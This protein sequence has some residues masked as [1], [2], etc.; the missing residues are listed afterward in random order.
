M[1]KLLL[2]LLCGFA[3]SGQVF[4]QSAI[5][6]GEVSPGVYENIK[7]DGTGHLQTTSATNASTWTVTTPTVTNSSTQILAANTARNFFS[8][9]NNST[10]G[11]IYLGIGATATTAMFAIA[12]G[13]TLMLSS[14]IPS[15]AINAIGSIAS[16][17]NVVVIEG[18]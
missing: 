13:Q 14:K 10:S 18:Q 11:T 6:R 2:G 15:T 4:A 8:V 1:K 16:N 9:Q 3:L 5:I 12:P 7:T 17:A